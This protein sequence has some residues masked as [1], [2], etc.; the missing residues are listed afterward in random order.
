MVVWIGYLASLFLALSLIVANAL[1]FRI[2]NILGCIIFIIYGSLIGAFP[3]I[4]ANGILLCINIF[5]LY[6]LHRSHE[7]F[8]YVMVGKND[9]IV[10]AFLTFYKK[11][12]A[13]YFPHFNAE[14]LPANQLSFVVL[15]DAAIANLFIATTDNN[16]NAF[17]TIDYTIP[18]Y[19]DYKVGRFIFEKEKSFLIENSIKKVV[20]EKVSNKK[21]LA[22][23]KIMGFTQE[24][25]NG[26]KC[27][28]KNLI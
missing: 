23:I 4:L 7:E 1:K 17:V 6:K 9:K 18:P 15:R 24:N 13:I 19:R 8:K 25:I 22:F 20:Y 12:I 2:F 27:W 10:A 11:D 5:Q 21:H 28:V 14:N 16:G 3:I 26:N